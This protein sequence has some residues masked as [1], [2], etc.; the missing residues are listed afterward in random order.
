MDG[1]LDCTHFSGVETPVPVLLK[2]PSGFRFR[3]LSNKEA[4]L[5]QAI[6][7]VI[8]S[9]CFSDI[10]HG[11]GTHDRAVSLYSVESSCRHSLRAP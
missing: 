11:H 7:V 9:R 5:C 4:L 10:N 1:R 2:D 6:F 8:F 3:A